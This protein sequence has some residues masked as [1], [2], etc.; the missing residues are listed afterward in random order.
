MKVKEDDRRIMIWHWRIP[1]PM[2]LAMSYR[3]LTMNKRGG[4]LS[5]SHFPGKFGGIF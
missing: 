1:D 2:K 5:F 3:Y 4:I